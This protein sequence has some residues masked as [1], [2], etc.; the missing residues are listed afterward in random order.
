[1]GMTDSVTDSQNIK[2]DI[3]R[4][5]LKK[6][7]NYTPPPPSPKQNIKLTGG[8][9]GKL[10]RLLQAETQTANRHME[11]I[12]R[13]SPTSLFCHCCTYKPTNWE[14]ESSMQQGDSTLPF[15]PRQLENKTQY[16]TVF[17]VWRLSK[18]FFFLYATTSTEE[19]RKNLAMKAVIDS[20]SVIQRWRW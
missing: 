20:E 7:T 2:L 9:M 4:D 17:L 10:I 14:M 16:Q 15:S 11:V 12:M 5:R 19:L 18:L 8:Q 1:M 6:N 3:Y 13:K